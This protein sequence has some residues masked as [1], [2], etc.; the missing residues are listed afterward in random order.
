VWPSATPV[1]ARLLG[2][3]LSDK[4]GRQFIIEN[5]PGAQPIPTPIYPLLLMFGSRE[6]SIDCNARGIGSQSLPNSA[7]PLLCWRPALV[8]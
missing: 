6:R 8:T 5:R 1:A 7:A 3:W 2:Q 4:L